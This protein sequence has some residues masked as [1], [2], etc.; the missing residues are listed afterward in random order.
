MQQISRVIR[1]E[2]LQTVKMIIGK[3]AM[4]LQVESQHGTGVRQSRFAVAWG[5][6]KGWLYIVACDKLCPRLS[7]PIEL[8]SPEPTQVDIDF[9]SGPSEQACRG[10]EYRFVRSPLDFAG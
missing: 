2:P 1:S 9:A 5:K 6:T 7:T 10:R 3:W 4:G 8:V